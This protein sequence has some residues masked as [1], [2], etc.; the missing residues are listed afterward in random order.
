M[1]SGSVSGEEYAWAVARVFGEIKAIRKEHLIKLY[2]V[3]AQGEVSE[4]SRRQILKIIALYPGK[5]AKRAVP[6]V[7]IDDKD[8]SAALARDYMLMLAGQDGDSDDAHGDFVR[9]FVGAAGIAADQVK[10]LTD[11]VHLENKVLRA[12]GAGDEWMADEKDW[13]ELGSRAAGVGL[14]VTALY[15]AGITGFSAVGLTSGLAAIG[16]TAGAALVALGLNPMTAGIAVLIAGGIAVKKFGDYALGVKSK[17]AAADEERARRIEMLVNTVA[18]LA[19]DR[20]VLPALT[21]GVEVVD[22]G[23]QVRLQTAMTEATNGLRTYAAKA[24]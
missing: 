12:M 15:F 24:K 9:S 14:P 21:A 18:M 13:R 4:T 22:T 8:L 17:K 19:A 3:F 20:E 2:Q 7:I 1:A 10:V 5:L 11:W 23:P 6:K 16:G